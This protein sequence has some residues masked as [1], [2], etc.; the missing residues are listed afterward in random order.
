M[1]SESFHSTLSMILKGFFLIHK[2]IY[3]YMH[4]VLVKNI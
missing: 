3:K 4:A 1:F 2:L